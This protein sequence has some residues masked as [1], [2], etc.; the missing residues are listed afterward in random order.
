[1]HEFELDS[2]LPSKEKLENYYRYQGSLTT[3]PCTENVIFNIFNQTIDISE[4]QVNIN[5]L[6]IFNTNTCSIFQ[7]IN[8]Y[9]L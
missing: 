4:S 5:F 1:M 2:I 9:Y 7:L 8:F 3:P 6:L